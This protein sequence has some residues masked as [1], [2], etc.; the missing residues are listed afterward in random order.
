LLRRIDT[1]LSWDGQEAEAHRCWSFC[2]EAGAAIEVDR[3]VTGLQID[4]SDV[5]GSEFVEQSRSDQSAYAFA[6]TGGIGRHPLDVARHCGWAPGAAN[7]AAHRRNSHRSEPPVHVVGDHCDEV[8]SDSLDE[9]LTRLYSPGRV[10]ASEGQRLPAVVPA[11]H[12]RW[13]HVRMLACLVAAEGLF[14][15][16]TEGEEV[17]VGEVRFTE[18]QTWVADLARGSHEKRAMSATSVLRAH[19]VLA[20]ILDNAVRDRRIASNPARGVALPRKVGREHRYLT[21]EELHRLAQASGQHATLIR[22]LGYSATPGCDGA[23]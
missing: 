9:V 7:T 14:Q 17:R 4:G 10:R 12:H 15:R 5:E 16:E 21:Q 11:G 20:G 8:S 18:V 6:A 13:S 19:G 3:S 23:R 22:L 2:G 1:A